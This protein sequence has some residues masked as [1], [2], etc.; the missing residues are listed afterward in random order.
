MPGEEVKGALNILL[1][2]MANLNSKTC[3]SEEVIH[4]D[5]KGTWV[6]HILPYCSGLL[7]TTEC[8]H[9]KDKC[10]YAQ[11]GYKYVLEKMYEVRKQK[12]RAIEEYQA[13]KE[14]RPER[15]V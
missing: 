9:P 7:D 13:L 6:V 2:E 14:G 5:E 15:P 1:A 4:Q 3:P 8:R 10:P 12:E 11:F